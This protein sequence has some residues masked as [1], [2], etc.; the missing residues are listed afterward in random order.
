MR[1]IYEPFNATRQ[2]VG[3]DTFAGFPTVA[4]KDGGAGM[5][6]PGVL[7]VAENYE[8]FL[9]RVLALR[10]SLDPLPHVMRMAIH[11]GDATEQLAAYLQSHPETIVAL[12][13][14]D[15]D[16]YEPT[17]ECLKLLKPFLTRGSVLAF[18]ELVSF[19]SPGETVA[20]REILG[21][22][23][24]RVRRSPLYSGHGSYIILGS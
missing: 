14:F 6:K 12:A 10:N 20:V 18:D 16:L 8:T 21:L 23:Q 9:S 19:V 4:P 15:M 3:F 7:S 11:R 13:H 22:D 1:T 5:M 24:I 17:K 2:I